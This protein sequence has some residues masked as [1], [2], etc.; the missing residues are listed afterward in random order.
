[1][2][3]ELHST[4]C[5]VELRT[6]PSCS[7]WGS[8]TRARGGS[9]NTKTLVGRRL[10]NAFRVHTT[11]CKHVRARARTHAQVLYIHITVC[12]ITPEGL[13]VFCL[14][15]GGQRSLALFLERARDSLLCRDLQGSL[16][17]RALKKL[18]ESC[19]RRRELAGASTGQSL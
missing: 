1:M 11:K 10:M 15:A 7:M 9:H 5:W 13:P 3:S 6:A 17:K 19:L 2:A 14:V 8:Q 18:P 4:Q 16:V 12:D